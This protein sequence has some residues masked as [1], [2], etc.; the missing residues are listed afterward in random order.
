[1]AF[2][3]HVWPCPRQSLVNYRI[4]RLSAATL[5]TSAWRNI[6]NGGVRGRWYTKLTTDAGT[7]IAPFYPVPF[8]THGMPNAVGLALGVLLVLLRAPF[9]LIWGVLHVLVVHCLVG[10]VLKAR[11]PLIYTAVRQESVR[12][13]LWIAGVHYVMMQ[14]EGG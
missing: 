9:L 8:D 13:A 6:H 12:C 7:G 2:Q 14:R 5:T 11:A 10:F 1:M 4:P 3:A